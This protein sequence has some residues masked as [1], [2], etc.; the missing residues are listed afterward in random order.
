MAIYYKRTGAL[1][2][3]INRFG[4]SSLFLARSEP[5]V[6]L[7]IHANS[8]I[9]NCELSTNHK[10][11]VRSAARASHSGG[12]WGRRRRRHLHI[13]RNTYILYYTYV[14]YMHSHKQSRIRVRQLAR[15]DALF[16]CVSRA[17]STPIIIGSLIN[18]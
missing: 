11:C 16:V 8:G 2:T 1:I 6:P 10:S 3:V 14:L 18:N 7:T 13:R 15:A 9:I 5:S 12:H 4:C 17:S